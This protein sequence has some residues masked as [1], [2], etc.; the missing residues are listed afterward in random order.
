MQFY[1][2]Y[3]QNKESNIALF[4]EFNAGLILDEVK[5][6]LAENPTDTIQFEK[7]LSHEAKKKYAGNEILA[8][9]EVNPKN[10]KPSK[11]VLKGNKTYYKSLT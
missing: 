2:L 6:H 11:C 9:Y 1:I 5:R 10:G 3:S 8:F 4:E 7:E